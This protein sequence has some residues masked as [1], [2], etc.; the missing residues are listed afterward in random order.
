MGNSCETELEISHFQGVHVIRS[1]TVFINNEVKHNF[2]VIL[3]L[4][5]G[6]S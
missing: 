2:K 5:S 3:S 6:Q 4:F 1:G